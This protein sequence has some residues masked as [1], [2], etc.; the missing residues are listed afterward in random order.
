MIEFVDVSK[1]FGETKVFHHLNLRIP[2]GSKLCIIGGSGAGKSVLTKLIVGLESPDSGD[3]RIEGQSISG[4]LGGD[5]SRLLD[6]FGVV[7]QGNALFDS[8]SIRD[9]IGLKLDENR[10]IPPTEVDR[11]VSEALR[12]VGLDDTLLTQYPENLSGGMQKRVGIARAIVHRPSYLIYDEPTSGLDPINADRID[13]L[14]AELGKEPGR[15]SIVITHDMQSVR[16]L[17]DQV[18]FLHGGGVYYHGEL[19]P[20]LEA[21]DPVIRAFMWRDRL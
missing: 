20:F 4:F 11:A 8:L 5:W 17:A 19:N 21:S 7:F 6:R 13:A 1:W 9:N 14:I 2:L 3:I 12:Q 10:A 15:T 16:Q 18:L